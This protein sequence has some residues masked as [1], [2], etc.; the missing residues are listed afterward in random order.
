MHTSAKAEQ[1]L[2]SL[3]SADRWWHEVLRGDRNLSNG[4]FGVEALKSVVY[5]D[6]KAWCDETKQCPDSG[7]SFW[8]ALRRR[9]GSV[10]TEKRG[11]Q[12]KKRP[13]QV[14]LPSR[15]ECQEA[16]AKA[17]GCLWSELEAL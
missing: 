16:F 7:T 4:V 17:I 11:R 6:Y 15:D 9:V 10:L 5:S 13:R 2:R 12:G 1:T 3:S 14:R 8:R